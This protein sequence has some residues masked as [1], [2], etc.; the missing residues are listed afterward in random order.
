MDHICDIVSSEGKGSLFEKV[1][2]R[3][4]KEHW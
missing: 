3:R 4:T 2:L 1:K